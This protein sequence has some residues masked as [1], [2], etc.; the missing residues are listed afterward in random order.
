MHINYHTI[1]ICISPKK[2]I[3]VNLIIGDYMGFLHI[4]SFHITARFM[5][6]SDGKNVD[7]SEHYSITSSYLTIHRQL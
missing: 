7:S 5:W 3:S 6:I 4:N 2:E 1:K